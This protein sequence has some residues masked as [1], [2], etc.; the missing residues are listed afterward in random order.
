MK[1]VVA[2]IFAGVVLFAA[3]A[4]A[5][6]ASAIPFGPAR[7]VVDP[8]AATPLDAAVALRV[9]GSLPAELVL[10]ALHA[11]MNWKLADS[12]ALAVEWRTPPHV[13]NVTVQLT[14][15]GADGSHRVGWATVQLRGLRSVLV[16]KR[17]LMKG[18]SLQAEDLGL[19]SRPV[20]DG[21]GVAIEPTVLAGAPLLRDV[22]AGA[23]IGAADIVM[24]APVARGAELTVL[25]KH[26]PLTISTRGTVERSAR[27]GEK[28]A[29]RVDDGHRIVYGRLLDGDTLLVEDK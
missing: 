25:V 3:S 26:G 10:V 12:D 7:E 6:S 18:E 14:L 19:E 13:G 29:A 20:A 23:V 24:P 15:D 21:E 5:Q 11:P 1:T 9:R 22:P 2:S 27:P 16:T 17:P 4:Q 28:S 8:T